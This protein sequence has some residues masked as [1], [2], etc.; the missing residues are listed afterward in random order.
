MKNL[1][2]LLVCVLCYSL[3]TA[4]DVNIT[5]NV[6][7]ENITVDPGGLYVA[8][9]ASFGAPGQAVNQLLDPDNDGIYSVTVVR[10][11]GFSDFYT[12]TN[13]NCPDFSCKEDIAGQSCAN[14]GNFNDRFLDVTTADVTINTCYE[15]CTTDGTCAPPVSDVVVTF[16]VDVSEYMDNPVDEVSVFGSFNGWNPDSNPLISVG[17]GIWEGSVTIAPT[18]IEYKFIVKSGGTNFEE[19]LTSG[20]PCTMTSGPYTNRVFTIP[21]GAPSD[22][23]TVCFGSCDACGGSAQDVTITL[24][25][26]TENITVDPGGLFLVGGATFGA[27]GSVPAN[28]LLDPDNDGIYTVT[29][30]RQQGFSDLY[31]FANG[32]CSDFSC[33]EDLSGQSCAVGAF[34]DREIA[35]LQADTVINTCYAQ[36]STDGTCAPPIVPVDV[37]FRV[38]MSEYTGNIASTNVFGTFNG[39][40]P[41]ANPM[42]D[43]GNGKYE[44]TISL[45]PGQAV[46]KFVVDDGAGNFIDEM[47]MGGESCTATGGGFTNRVADIPAGGPFDIGD[48]CFASCVPCVVG[49]E[50]VFG[51]QALFT[52]NPTLVVNQTFI[53][54]P[55]LRQDAQLEVFNATG[56]QFFAAGIPAGTPNYTLRTDN[57]ASGIYFVAIR[58]DSQQSIQKIVVSK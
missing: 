23:G 13:G 36:C 2:L 58:T 42:T 22:I 54:F 45:N 10:P 29:V 26:N 18:V 46:Y 27:P 55:N 31:A 28:Q 5:F 19:S 4:Q 6:N 49:L 3:T 44:T 50:T 11:S 8:G 35:N 40:N 56:Q 14:P 39:F 38:D 24:N 20:D 43:M 12:F 7:T 52:I 57:L 33:K 32:P 17:N 34:N 53:Q 37:T 16:R 30:T 51:D 41:A 15:Q 21:A 1:L 47:F 9:G 25:V 48:V